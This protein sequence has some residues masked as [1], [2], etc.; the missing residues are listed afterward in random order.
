MSHDGSNGA[1]GASAKIDKYLRILEAN[2]SSLVFAQLAE[3]L[4]E[5][6]RAEE[7][8]AVCRK[9]LEKHPTFVDGHYV[10]GRCLQK[11]GHKTE[12]IEA[13]Q[14]VLARNPNHL[15]ARQGLSALGGETFEGGVLSPQ[16]L[17]GTEMKREGID[18][19]PLPT[20]KVSSEFENIR[21]RLWYNDDKTPYKPFPWVRL[22]VAVLLV[23]IAG[24]GVYVYFS[25]KAAAIDKAVE[26]YQERAL[27]EIGRL[28]YGR[29]SALVNDIS[30]FTEQHPRVAVQLNPVSAMLAA[31]LFGEYDRTGHTWRNL[32]DAGVGPDYNARGRTVEFRNMASAL[33]AYYENQLGGTGYYL[34]LI[35]RSAQMGTLTETLRGALLFKEDD[36]AGGIGVLEKVLEKDTTAVL[37]R[38]MLARMY[39]R[40]GSAAKAAKMLQRFEDKNGPHSLL[41]AYRLLALSYD[42]ELLPP[43]NQSAHEFL[44]NGSLPPV[45]GVLARLVLASDALDAGEAKVARVLLDRFP[46]SAY[47]CPRY[48]YLSGVAYR[49]TGNYAKAETDIQ[50]AIER[51]GRKVAYLSELIRIYHAQQNYRSLLGAFDM[52]KEDGFEDPRLWI[53]VGDAQIAMDNYDLAAQLYRRALFAQPKDEYTM[54]HYARSLINGGSYAQADRFIRR[55]MLEYKD[56]PFPHYLN[57][58]LWLARKDTA[59]AEINFKAA[60]DRRPD[61]TDALFALAHLKRETGDVKGFVTYAK[62]LY[63][64]HPDYAPG[65][66]YWV[67]WLIF[68]GRYQEARDILWKIKDAPATCEMQLIRLRG[69]IL[70]LREKQA[71]KVIT[72][73]SADD[74]PDD[75]CGLRYALLAYAYALSGFPDKVTDAAQ[76]ALSK[77]GGCSE[78]H[79]YVGDAVLEQHDMGWAMNEFRTALEINPVQ[80]EV[81]FRLGVLYIKRKMLGEAKVLME[82]A[83][84]WYNEAPLQKRRQAEIQYWLGVIS[85]NQSHYPAARRYFDAALKRDPGLALPYVAMAKYFY[86]GGNNKLALSTLMKALRIQKDNPQAIYELGDVYRIMGR[87]KEAVAH[88]KKYLKLAPDGPESDQC[89]AFLE[90]LEGGR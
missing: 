6:N 40:T 21:E 59:K 39:M 48:R 36:R 27:N 11:L 74:Y 54:M 53:M 80:P 16:I 32:M 89:R 58:M 68:E 45:F 4:L 28:D 14:A 83:Q 31:L 84:K 62:T 52:M 71:L 25:M 51:D 47:D 8:L 37:P 42:Q 44:D 86:K 57:G 15:L 78:V 77:G 63:T 65:I 22:I 82:K 33:R 5:T 41:E 76:K 7:A 73:L 43:D 46:V 18:P 79:T 61:Y 38:V 50:K 85:I 75:C 1:Q 72:A 81:M 34:Q 67:D 66:S 69:S 23:V 26:V 12:A 64:S 56:K 24:S 88:F 90:E 19:L 49:M 35:P 10:Y 13:F 3:L 2:P 9:G 20:Q 60:L 70:D 87:S 55:L 17:A 30:A 29:M